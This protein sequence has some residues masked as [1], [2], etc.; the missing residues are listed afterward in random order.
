MLTNIAGEY[1][2]ASFS[3]INVYMLYF[4]DL[5]L[6]SHTLWP[7]SDYFLRKQNLAASVLSLLCRMHL[8]HVHMRGGG[9]I[10]RF[11]SSAHSKTAGNANMQ[12]ANCAGE[13]HISNCTESTHGREQTRWA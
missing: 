4:A 11:C 7:Q 10:V 12:Q 9:Q 5:S 8:A 1:T 6:L 3:T 13:E 2:F